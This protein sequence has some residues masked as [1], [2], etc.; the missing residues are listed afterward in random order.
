MK[1]RSY[2]ANHLYQVRIK[3]DLIINDFPRLSFFVGK[4]LIPVSHV[5]KSVRLQ[6]G[7]SNQLAVDQIHAN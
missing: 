6:V 7:T 1:S 4:L 2:T 5:G 3:T